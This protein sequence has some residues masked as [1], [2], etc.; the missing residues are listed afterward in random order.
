MSIPFGL[1]IAYLLYTFSLLYNHPQKRILIQ[2][3]VQMKKLRLKVVKYSAQ[4]HKA[5]YCRYHMAVV[6]TL[7]K[8]LFQYHLHRGPYLTALNATLSLYR[9][10]IFY[11]ILYFSLSHDHHLK[12]YTLDYY[13][14]PLLP[15]ETGPLPCLIR[16]KHHTSIHDGGSSLNK[17]IHK[18]FCHNCNNTMD[19]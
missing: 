4:E 7:F 16:Y 1:D 11:L 5:T 19:L 10:P 13:L 8:C 6:L 14:Y 12:Y 18:E 3:V 17:Y 9:C 15:I 2:S